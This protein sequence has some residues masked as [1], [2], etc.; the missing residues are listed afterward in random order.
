MRSLLALR[1]LVGL[2]RISYGV[3]LY[4]W[5]IYVILDEA[6]T[7]L[8][9]PAL[10]GLRLV[11]TGIAATLSYVLIERPIRRRRLAAAPDAGRFARR[12]RRRRRA[13]VARP[14][15]DRRRLLAGGAGRHRG[16][17]SDGTSPS[18]PPVDRSPPIR[19]RQ[20]TVAAVEPTDR[21]RG[22]AGLR[23]GRPRR[24]PSTRQRMPRTP[25]RSGARAPGR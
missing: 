22:T 20:S 9:G 7:D 8:S 13:A 16:A 25:P 11:A 12:H 24:R 18:T 15:A 3:Y 21:R 5:P 4:H 23:G 1:P 2:G 6:R 17:G 14:G 10:L 19:S